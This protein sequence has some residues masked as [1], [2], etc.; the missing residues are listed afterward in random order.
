[1]SKD[2][3]LYHKYTVHN[4]RTGYEVQNAFVLMPLKDDLAL[5]ALKHYLSLLDTSSNLHK[6]LSEWIIKI[7]ASKCICKRE[8]PKGQGFTCCY[9]CNL[10]NECYNVCDIVSAEAYSDCPKFDEI[11]L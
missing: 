10:I 1:M 5:E 2:L 7:E 4:N 6:D 8:C 11:D 3:G 9:M